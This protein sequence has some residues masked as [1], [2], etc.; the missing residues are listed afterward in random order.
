VK[1]SGCARA[2]MPVHSRPGPCAYHCARGGCI[3]APYPSA[4]CGPLPLFLLQREGRCLPPA[5]AAKWKLRVT[6][7]AVTAGRQ[8]SVLTAL[9]EHSPQPATAAGKARRNRV[10]GRQVLAGHA[11]MGAAIVQKI[12]GAA[13]A[14][15]RG[16]ARGRA[17]ARLARQGSGA[18]DAPR[19]TRAAVRRAMERLQR[20]RRGC[21]G[22]H[23]RATLR[24]SKPHSLGAG[25]HFST[26][27]V[28][29][30]CS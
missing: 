12:P 24:G 27:D 15:C 18:A 14:A 29:R 28:G 7:D 22:G 10:C 5:G 1:N 21:V 13:V 20:G 17:G 2:Q 11:S 19:G 16:H 4:A 30:P 9:S 6:A 25:T 23:D 3:Q 8:P 26:F